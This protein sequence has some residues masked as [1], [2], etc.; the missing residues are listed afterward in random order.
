MYEFYQHN[1]KSANLGFQT[2]LISTVHVVAYEIYHQKKVPI[3]RFTP[4]HRTSGMINRE[5]NQL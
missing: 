4:K 2:H 3:L 5:D 1:T